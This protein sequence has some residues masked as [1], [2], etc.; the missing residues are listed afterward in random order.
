MEERQEV[1]KTGGGWSRARRVARAK[2]AVQSGESSDSSL[3]VYNC[4]VGVG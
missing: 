1:E 2:L 4:Q 3:D